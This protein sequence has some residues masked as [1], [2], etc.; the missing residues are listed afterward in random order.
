MAEPN[1]PATF[2]VKL[3]SRKG[4][5]RVV[6]VDNKGIQDDIKTY[7]DTKGGELVGDWYW[8]WDDQDVYDVVAKARELDHKV[9]AY[10]VQ[11]SDG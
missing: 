11:I 6:G 7:L 9:A 1:V 5:T 4:L 3:Y 8:F 10:D 2:T